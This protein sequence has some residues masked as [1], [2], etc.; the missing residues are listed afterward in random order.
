MIHECY[1]PHPIV[2]NLTCAWDI[3]T[4]MEPIEIGLHYLA[5]PHC[6]H[7]FRAQDS[8]I[9]FKYKNWAKD[10]E[11]L[12]TDDEGVDLVRVSGINYIK[13]T[14]MSSMGNFHSY[15]TCKTN[16]GVHIRTA[17]LPLARYYSL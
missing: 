3:K 15:Y 17:H 9:K 8:S 1:R 16:T 14:K 6:F 11:W 7:L 12:P 2:Q 5:Y 4:W 10:L 13:Q